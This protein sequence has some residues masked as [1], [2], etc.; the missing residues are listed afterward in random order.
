[1]RVGEGSGVVG[2]EAGRL[3]GAR[4]RQGHGREG[5]CSGSWPH[6]PLVRAVGF[7]AVF[8]GEREGRG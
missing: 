4:G 1:M 7:Y 5:L 6:P 8:R 2:G 3:G